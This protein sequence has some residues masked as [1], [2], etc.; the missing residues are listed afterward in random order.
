MTTWTVGCWGWRLTPGFPTKPYVYVLY[1][2]DAAIGGTPPAWP[3]TAC[4]DAHGTGCMVSG[5]LSRLQA[6]GDHMTG[7]EQVLIN[8]WCQQ[9]PSHSV[10]DLAFGADGALYASGGEGASY[11]AVDYGQFGGNPCA[12]PPA[13]AGGSETGSDGR[14][15]RTAG[16]EPAPSAYRACAAEWHCDPRKP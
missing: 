10:G 3:N 9:F 16:P 5:R 6:S 2:Y 11:L 12:D 8:A 1:T 14:G 4:P 15:R 7:S 13:G